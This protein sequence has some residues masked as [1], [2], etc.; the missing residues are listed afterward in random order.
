MLIYDRKEIINNTLCFKS[1][2]CFDS[3]TLWNNKMSLED[4][5]RNM[6]CK[7]L[8]TMSLTPEVRLGRSNNEYRCTRNCIAHKY[9]I[10]KSW[11]KLLHVQFVIFIVFNLLQATESSITNEGK[12]SN[13]IGRVPMF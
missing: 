11:R 13:N 10:L 5:T 2:N 12:L 9:H 3:L 7:I 4:E 6:D 8:L 1:G